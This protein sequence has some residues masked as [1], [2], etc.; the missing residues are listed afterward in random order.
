LRY[1]ATFHDRDTLE[2]IRAGM[3]EYA[4]LVFHEQFL[5]DDEHIAFA[6]RF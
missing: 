3:D 4:V 1:C 6:Q 2:Q 5:T